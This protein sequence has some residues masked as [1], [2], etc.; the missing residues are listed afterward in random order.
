VPKFMK[1]VKYEQTLKN[2]DFDSIATN[3]ST[4]T[5]NSTPERSMSKS[6]R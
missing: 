6:Q 3:G 2:Y 4:S 1:S 5:K